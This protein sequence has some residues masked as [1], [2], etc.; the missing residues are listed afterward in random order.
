M[1]IF[2]QLDSFACVFTDEC[3]LLLQCATICA[4]DLCASFVWYSGLCVI[5]GIFYRDHDQL[6]LGI[7][8]ASVGY[9][10]FELHNFSN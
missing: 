9:Q 6:V 3:C 2:G 4:A 10:R 5:H 1:H 7:S 8:R